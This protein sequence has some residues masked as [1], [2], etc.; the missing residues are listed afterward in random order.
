MTLPSAKLGCR[1]G[2]LYPFNR[3]NASYLQDGELPAGERERERDK[4]TGDVLKDYPSTA[5]KP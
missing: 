2:I 3:Q 4:T 5:A 1:R